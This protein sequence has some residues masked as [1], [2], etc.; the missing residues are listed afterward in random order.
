MA[1]LG[2]RLRALAGELAVAASAPEEELRDVVRG[3]VAELGTLAALQ[4]LLGGVPSVAAGPVDSEPVPGAHL[5]WQAC[6]ALPLEAQ[7]VRG[8][9][10]ISGHATPLQRS[11]P[12][13]RFFFRDQPA[14]YLGSGLAKLANRCVN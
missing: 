11:L 8:G 2:A 14:L 12:C 13:E 6:T 4:D 5:E 7:G 3:A 1:E 10:G 9:A